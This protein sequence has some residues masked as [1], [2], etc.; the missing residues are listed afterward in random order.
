MRE[1]TACLA[2]MLAA[3]PA[4]SALSVAVRPDKICVKPGQPVQVQITVSGLPAGQTAEV[5]CRLFIGLN[6]QVAKAAGRTNEQGVLIINYTPKAEWGYGV[7]ATATAGNESAT[8][9]E[10][11]A[12]A[13]NPYMVEPGYQVAAVYGQDTLPDGTPAPLGKPVN[14]WIQK[15]VIEQVAAMREQYVTVAELMGPAFC[16]F[17]A[18]KPPVDNYFK[19]Y[20]YNYSTNGVRGLV[21]VLRENG[22]KSVIYVNACLSGLA[23][24]EFAR[25]HPE[26]LAYTADG[27]PYAEVSLKSMAA[28]QEYI[29]NYPA[30][31]QRAVKDPKYAEQLRS[32]YPGFLNALMDFRD[33][34]LSEYGAQFI[35]E[36]VKYFGLDGVRFDGHYSIPSI[37]DPLAP[38]RDYRNFKG[39]PQTSGPAA[40]KMTASNMRLAYSLMRKGNPDFLIG[41]NFADYRS[42]AAGDRAVTSPI[43]KAVSPGNWILDEVAKGALSPAAPEHKWADFMRLMSEQTDRVRLVD[44]YL[45]AGWGGGPGWYALDTKYI[46]AISY[47]CGFRWMHGGFEKDPKFVVPWREA[48]HRYH[49]FTFRYGEFILNNRLRR[50]PSA[51]A[52]KLV[53][54]QAS[55]PIFWQYFVQRLETPQGRFL[56]LHLINAPEE[57]GI[58]KEAKPVPPAS[59]VRVTL[60]PELFGGRAPKLEVARVLSPD[61]D[62]Q[63]QPLKV[64][65][66]G[67]AL[68]LTIPQVELWTMVVLPY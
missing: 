24:T 7:L 28:H 54:V 59:N 9:Y 6:T 46:K 1:I 66:Q 51:E 41:L 63:A 62:P 20:H 47:A 13:K 38:T 22:I 39:E 25:Q 30:S 21:D 2:I 26:F 36:G 42:D 57:A 53:Q 44:N 14:P 18:I 10:V 4:L 49:Q 19:G 17:S 43:G 34:K 65:P 61:T 40:E 5:D 68:V 12:C 8:G 56:V 60:A 31:L 35:L 15:A 48:I 64:V 27:A 11:F 45:T 33:P 32:S 16:S 58:T 37:G 55:R 52:Q 29:K 50:I 23:G 3:L 67:R